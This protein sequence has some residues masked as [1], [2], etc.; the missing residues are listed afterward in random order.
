MAARRAGNRGDEPGL[1]PEATPNVRRVPTADRVREPPC[2]THRLGRDGSVG[3]T[4]ELPIAAEAL[5]LLPEARTEAMCAATVASVPGR[6]QCR[7][8]R[9]RRASVTLATSGVRRVVTPSS[10]PSETI[11][12]DTPAVVYLDP[13]DERLPTSA[14]DPRPGRHRP[15][16]WL[17]DRRLAPPRTRRHRTR[18]G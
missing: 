5:A 10:R 7:R 17:T 11:L 3:S 4:I 14:R 8:D 12:V 18:L 9:C 1:L 16:E 13:V 6:G 15:D 2:A